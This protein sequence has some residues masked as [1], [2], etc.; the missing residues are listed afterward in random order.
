MALGQKYLAHLLDDD[1][2]RGNLFMLA[3]AYNAGPGT[4]RRWLK[5]VKFDDDPLLFIES[6]PSG[7]TRIFIERVVA[8]FWIYRERLGQDSPSLDAV[9]VGLWPYYVALDGAT[10]TVARHAQD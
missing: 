6:I 4:L 7:E 9:A 5:T 3:A 2:V 10:M 8:N 1:S